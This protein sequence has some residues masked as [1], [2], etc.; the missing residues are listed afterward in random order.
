MVGVCSL[1]KDQDRHRS[2]DSLV[3][4]NI[5]DN[6][7]DSLSTIHSILKSQQQQQ[8]NIKTNRPDNFRKHD[9]LTLSTIIPKN[10]K[11]SHQKIEEKNCAQIVDENSSQLNEENNKNFELKKERGLSR[12]NA[13]RPKICEQLI[14]ETISNASSPSDSLSSEG[15]VVNS[16]D[17]HSPSHPSDKSSFNVTNIFNRRISPPHQQQQNLSAI[18]PTSARNSIQQQQQNEA[19]E[20]GKGS[21]NKE[22]RKSSSSNQLISNSIFYV[23]STTTAVES[24]TTTPES[25]SS[26]SFDPCT[27]AL[28]LKRGW[29]NKIFGTSPRP[30]ICGGGG[31]SEVN[32]EDSVQLEKLEKIG[33]DRQQHET[34][35]KYKKRTESKPI[36]ENYSNSLTKTCNSARSYNDLNNPSDR[37]NIQSSSSRCFITEEADCFHQRSKSSETPITSQS[38]NNLVNFLLQHVPTNSTFANPSYVGMQENQK[39]LVSSNTQKNQAPIPKPRTSLVPSLGAPRQISSN[40]Q[41]WP[42]SIAPML[43]KE[44]KTS[45]ASQQQSSSLVVRPNTLR[46]LPPPQQTTISPLNKNNLLRQCDSGIYPEGSTDDI[47][48]CVSGHTFIY[49]KETKLQH[50]DYPCTSSDAS[51][52][53]RHRS[54]SSSGLPLSPPPPLPPK[55]IQGSRVPKLPYDIMN[56]LFR[57]NLFNVFKLQRRLLWSSSDKEFFANVPRLADVS[58]FDAKLVEAHYFERPKGEDITNEDGYFND[59]FRMVLPPPNVT[60]NLH[61]GHAL[62]VVVEDSIC[63]FNKL[64]GNYVCWIPGFDHAGIATQTVVEKQI[65]RKFGKKREEMSNGE[66]LNYCENWKNERITDITKQLKS[67][68]CSLDWEY[69]FYTMDENFSNAV[70]T[71]FVRLYDLGLIT[72]ET[73]LVQSF[74]ENE[75]TMKEQWFLKMTE[76]NRELLKDVEEESGKLNFD[77]ATVKG[78]LIEFLKFEEPWCLSRQLVWGHKIPAYFVENSKRWIVALTEEDARKQLLP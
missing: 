49:F 39:A 50:L 36:D 62:T 38:R 33:F 13:V 34:T 37:R 53:I 12:T 19:N 60:G 48:F 27:N 29:M 64:L 67:L 6:K 65:L 16:E 68:G 42:T 41:P 47:G 24:K 26:S 45:I 20:H 9:Y 54:D 11:I 31:D 30:S 1:K 17:F 70:K 5:E 15:F 74:N 4:Q 7:E 21:I 78:N 75:P 63:R 58:K 23:P 57:R 40:D 71:A 69:L 28:K 56:M 35:S 44:S 2:H 76:M 43:E 55:R 18:T 61:V 66:F 32:L 46:L 10:S 77:P 25:D 8:K 3:D 14:P 22:N 73:R 72:R 59:I 51:P 52:Q